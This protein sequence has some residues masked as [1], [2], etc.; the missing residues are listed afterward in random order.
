M[1]IVFHKFKTHW[2]AYKVQYGL[3]ILELKSGH[4]QVEL[5]EA[6]KALT[7][8]MTGRSGSIEC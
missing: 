5:E 7:A 4:W 8:F 1:P 6:S 3:L 2:P